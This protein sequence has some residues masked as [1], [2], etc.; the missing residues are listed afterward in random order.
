M[1]ETPLEKCGAKG[2]PYILSVFVFNCYETAALSALTQ[3]VDPG[4]SRGH[5]ALHHY[6]FF[7]LPALPSM[8]LSE[9]AIS[10]SV[11][12]GALMTYL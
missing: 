3:A 7:K 4:S 5:C 12:F 11:K 2:F 9:A 6:S 1:S 10:T 8:S